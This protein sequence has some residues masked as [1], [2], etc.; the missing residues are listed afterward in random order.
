M[1]E[2]NHGI[3]GPLLKAECDTALSIIRTSPDK[4]RE[5]YA[6]CIDLDPDN[7]SYRISWN[8]EIAFDKTA[9]YYREKGNDNESLYEFFWGTKYNSGDF[10]F[11]LDSFETYTSELSELEKALTLHA[12]LRMKADQLFK[13]NEVDE[14][15]KYVEALNQKLIDQA[16]WAINQLNFEEVDR[17]GDFIAFVTLHDAS[18]NILLGLM[19]RTIPS[20]IYERIPEVPSWQRRD[21]S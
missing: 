2:L 6:F 21:T 17:T 15:D 13:E 4:F 5:V 3:F 18:A 12:E 8:T 11:H 9:S 7:G 10:T 20:S 14:V 16:V 1:D 19:Q